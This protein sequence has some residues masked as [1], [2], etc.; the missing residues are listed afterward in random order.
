M[1]KDKLSKSE[2]EEK[3]KKT[4]SENPSPIKIKKIK[5]LAM[6]KNIKLREQKKLFC[7][8]CL[9]V[10]NSKN[11]ETRIQNKNKIVRCKNCG[12]I[13]RRKLI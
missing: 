3:I 1:N 4:F 10:F 8:K 12:F 13:S 6:S 5:T 7:K 9:S 11:S 2:I